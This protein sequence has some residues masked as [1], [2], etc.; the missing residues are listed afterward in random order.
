MKKFSK[1]P[2]ATAM[3]TLVLSSLASNVNADANPFALTE[4]SGA[5]MQV[6]VTSSEAEQHN[7]QVSEG[8]CAS[9]VA[10]AH[11]KHG[12]TTHTPKMTEGACGEGKCGAMMS[13]GKMN[14]GMENSCGAMMKGKE[15][16][17]GMMN[18]PQGNAAAGH[19]HQGA[20][21]T[22]KAPEH[23]CGSAMMGGKGGEGSCGAGMQSHETKVDADKAAGK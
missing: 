19:D 13:G 3:G 10:P 15:G 5:Y 21:D 1:T 12:A 7:K 18:M 14:K 20:A 11:P 23:M 22:S 6:A 16:A 17:C 4:M 8:G 2:F 9:N